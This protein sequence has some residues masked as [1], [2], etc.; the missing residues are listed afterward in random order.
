MDRGAIGSKSIQDYLRLKPDAFEF[1]NCWQSG[2]EDDFRVVYLNNN[3]LDGFKHA[4]L[5][6]CMSSPSIDYLVLLSPHG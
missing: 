2:L 1:T 4:E 5:L 3:G 6:A